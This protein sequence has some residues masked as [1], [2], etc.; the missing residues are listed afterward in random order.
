MHIFLIIYNS[1]KSYYFKKF[2]VSINY[3]PMTN[4]N[5]K[6]VVTISVTTLKNLYVFSYLDKR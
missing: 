2:K 4:L 6:G 5:K 1:I 3:S